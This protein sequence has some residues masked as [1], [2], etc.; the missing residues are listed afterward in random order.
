MDIG[1]MLVIVAF[2]IAGRP[3]LLSMVP[4][5]VP[6]MTPFELVASHLAYICTMCRLKLDIEAVLEHLLSLP[7]V[8]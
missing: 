5:L 7:V 4:Q 3:D 8:L 2:V 6:L 1:A